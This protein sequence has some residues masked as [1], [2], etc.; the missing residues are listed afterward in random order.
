M[1]GPRRGSAVQQGHR[2]GAGPVGFEETPAAQHRHT[3]RRQEPRADGAAPPGVHPGA[4]RLRR[5]ARRT[6]RVAGHF[7]REGVGVTDRGDSGHSPD[8][9]GE[10]VER[11]HLRGEGKRTPSRRSE[12]HG[13]L[14]EARIRIAVRAAEEP[15]RASRNDPGRDQHRARGRGPENEEDSG[16]RRSRG[17]TREEDTGRRANR[18]QERGRLRH[19]GGAGREQRAPDGDPLAH[20]LRERVA[21]AAGVVANERIQPT[22]EQRTEQEDAPGDRGNAKPRGRGPV[23][24]VGPD[25]TPNGFRPP[26]AEGARPAQPDDAHR[27]RQ[28]EQEGPHS[29]DFQGRPDPGGRRVL[30][31]YEA[32]GRIRAFAGVFEQRG[33][34]LPRGGERPALVQPRDRR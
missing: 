19:E 4:G 20:T 1:F 15:E 8:A 13:D 17:R 10:A 27:R 18:R 30:E 34:F 21:G 5:G 28:Q 6:P 22:R 7:V 14:R 3:E 33:R 2:L 24:P 11:L 26:F 23:P 32:N 12:V 16:E 31:R 25:R 9:A 29:Q